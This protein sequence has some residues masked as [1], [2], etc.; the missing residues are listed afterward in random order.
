MQETS[1]NIISTVTTLH[2][3][4]PENSAVAAER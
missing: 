4:L 2:D 1:K 3:W